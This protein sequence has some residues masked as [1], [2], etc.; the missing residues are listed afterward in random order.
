MVTSV[1]GVVVLLG[2]LIFFHELG[3]YLVAKLFGVRV[4]VFSLGFGKKI[5]RRQVGETEYC[6]SL[7]PLGGYVKLMGDDPY[8]AVPAEDAARAFST[9]KLYKRFLIVAAGPIANFLLAFVL[10]IVIFWLG[11]PVRT[12]KIG[13]V[14]PASPAWDAGL[15]PG[16]R[17][18]SVGNEPV[19]YWNEL[20]E[21]LK[22][23]TGQ[24]VDLQVDRAGA[25]LRIPYTIGLVRTRNPYGEEEEVGGIKGISPYPVL[26]A[27]GV[28]DPASAAGH[29]GLKTGDTIIKVD[30]R[31]VA[32]WEEM[33][34]ALAAY[35]Q[36]GKPVTITF[37]RPTGT[38]DKTEE[39][40]ATLVFPARPTPDKANLF[41]EVSA[42]GLYPTELFVQKVN[43]DSPA[44]KGGLLVGD[45]VVQVA[46]TPVF[47]FEMIVDAVQ[48]AGEKGGP[49]MFS[50]ER[51]GQKVQLEL[52]PVE[53]EVED[54]LTHQKK[55][56]FLVG[57]MPQTSLSEAEMGKFQIRKPLELIPHA[58]G[59]TYR[60][61]ERMVV[62]LA[63]LVTGSVSVK[64]LGGPVLI[65]SIAGKSLDAGIVPFLQT[66]AL[67]SINLF[68]L[69]LFPIPVLDGGHLLFFTMEAIKGK[70]VSIRV[71]EM[72]NQVGLV[73]ILMLV[74]LT[75][76]NDISRIVMH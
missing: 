37:K 50:L 4:E 10:F 61:S 8:R 59:E 58:L 30:N 47:H 27:V 74:A 14:A 64:N 16:D 31:P 9:Q 25:Q 3:H 49:L 70:P 57:F 55:K 18:V 36:P 62:S 23:R 41:G 20:D 75:F 11:Q 42:L 13:F 48:G 72:A 44:E 43:P 35:W 33:R 65:A 1:V 63:K 66:M 22:A 56:R 40:S 5:F 60:I 34:E 51:G 19:Q 52:K 7:I 32:L 39:K 53:T 69:N 38:G 15:R 68:L 6:L 46:G 76:F 71:M 73:L 45:R 24:K 67:I 28:S 21:D 17:L 12:S 2:G 54:P 29:A 26:A